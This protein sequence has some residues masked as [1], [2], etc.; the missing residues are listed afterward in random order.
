MKDGVLVRY[1]GQGGREEL[2]V[3]FS[4]IIQGK[5]PDFLV[6]ADDIIFIPGS[7]FKTIGYGLL[8]AIPNTASGAVI[9]GP[10][11]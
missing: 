3:N 1:D 5:K 10:V 9:N 11:R 4:D 8:G 7:T 2:A 6:M